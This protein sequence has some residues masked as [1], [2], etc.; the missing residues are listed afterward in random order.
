[1]IKN[2]CL[3]GFL[4]LIL[5]LTGCGGNSQERAVEDFAKKFGMMAKYGDVNGVKDVSGIKGEINSVSLDY[6]E[7]KI[8][9]F[10]QGDD[11]YK[12]N[13]GN[14]AYIVVTVGLHDAIEVIESEGIINGSNNS[15]DS[16]A[17]AEQ[18]AS[19]IDNTSNSPQSVQANS[20]ADEEAIKKFAAAFKNNVKAEKD[21]TFGKPDSYNSG[22]TSIYVKNSNGKEVDGSD[23]YISFKYEYD[24]AEGMYSEDVKQ[25]GKNI[26][27]N[28][29]AKFTY[30]YT[31]DCSPR[32]VKVH[33][34][35]TDKQIYDKYAN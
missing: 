5:F 26:S 10:P 16:K 9:I 24:Y 15:E 32:P 22:S 2:N 7:N 19:N 13:Y 30:H 28:G 27:A 12:I 33:F 29:K 20:T 23:Y 31:D 17:I 35:L 14:G 21:W 4:L 34:K 25:N 3:I 1:M 6:D 18:S 11:R 8:K